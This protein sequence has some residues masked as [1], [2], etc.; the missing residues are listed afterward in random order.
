MRKKIILVLTLLLSIGFTG[1]AQNSVNDVTGVVKD[2]W[3]KP[4]SGALV[5]SVENSEIKTFTDKEGKFKI[6]LMKSEKIR[7]TSSDNSYLIVEPDYENHMTIT[8]GYSSQAV[9]IGYDKTF[10]LEES[11]ASVFST[12]SENLNNLSARDIGS[13]LYG[14]ILGLTALQGAGKAVNPSIFP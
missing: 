10:N 12:Y 3:G 9:N 13:T 4:V 11:T 7:I 2:Q 5:T 6:N 8:M 1:L 14:N